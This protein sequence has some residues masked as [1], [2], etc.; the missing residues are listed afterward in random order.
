MLYERYVDDIAMC[1]M[2]TESGT[3]YKDNKLVIDE[4]LREN[5][6]HIS[7][8]QRTFTL[9]KIIGESIHESIKL[10]T[11]VPSNH[12]DKKLPLL[13]LKVYIVHDQFEDNGNIITTTKILHE[14]YMK[15]MSC[16]S[17][18]HKDSALSISTKR[19]ILTQM[20][21]RIILNCSSDL[22]WSITTGHLTTFI[23]ECK[24]Q[25]MMKV[26]DMRF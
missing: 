14:Y 12:K 16:K 13:D 24:Y 20:C 8:D 9:I 1:V 4:V 23:S 6:E 5:E 21:L 17:V 11:D 15:E 7:D 3:V 18:I 26:F 22:P 19:T 2:S 25:A 10:E